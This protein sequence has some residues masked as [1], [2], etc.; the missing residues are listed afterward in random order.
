[1]PGSDGAPV[2]H[3]L[4]DPRGLLVLDPGDRAEPGHVPL[5]PAPGHR[6][7]VVALLR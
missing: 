1:M 4:L 6:Q 2:H 5:V 3:E 7:Q